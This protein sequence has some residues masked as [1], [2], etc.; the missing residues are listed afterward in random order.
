MW[1]RANLSAGFSR[2]KNFVL[3][4]NVTD[5]LK[6]FGSTFEVMICNSDV[7]FFLFRLIKLANSIMQL[8]SE[9]VLCVSFLS[10]SFVS[11]FSWALDV[12]NPTFFLQQT[13][14][15]SSKEAFQTAILNARFATKQGNIWWKRTW[16]F[17]SRNGGFVLD[18]HC[19][20]HLNLFWS[21]N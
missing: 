18:L 1:P 11:N 21:D 7:K 10:A 13:P 5:F 8:Q 20:N 17:S 19:L 15:N 9:F 3:H 14:T 4:T 6:T 12:A 16:W 2:T